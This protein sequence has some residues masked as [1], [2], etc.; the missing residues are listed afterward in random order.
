MGEQESQ[1]AYLMFT[2]SL[3]RICSPNVLA[4][5]ICDSPNVQMGEQESR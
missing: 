5:T 3:V 1:Y 4:S 2:P